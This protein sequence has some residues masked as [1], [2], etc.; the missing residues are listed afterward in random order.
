MT[1]FSSLYGARLTRELGTD[2]IT[3]LFT[4]ALR[5]AA[6]NEAAAE[7]AD[8]TECWLKTSSL[9]LTAG[10]LEYNIAS[11]AVLAAGDF[12]RLS[13]DGGVSFIYV[14]ASSVKTVLSGDDLLRRDVRWLDANY[15][16]WRFSTVASS[17]QQWPTYWYE[18]KKNGGSF[19]GFVPVPS[20]GSSASMEALLSYVAQPPVMTSDTSEPFQ[21][22]AVV[23]TDL[24]PFHQGLVH[25]A[26]AI[27]ERLRRDTAQSDLQMQ[28]FYTYVTR[29][30]GSLRNKG[31]RTVTFARD[32]FNPRGS[33]RGTDPR[34]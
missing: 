14:D 16:A 34:R 12:T 18:Q 21:S 23:R 31:G 15:Q 25:Y 30:L 22:G 1:Q 8:L 28:L 29:F 13:R 2:D 3:I 17:A 24:R 19:L 5:K 6:I 32:Y 11:T 27:L 20:T 4:T 26:A 10:T 33:D 9:T 7:F